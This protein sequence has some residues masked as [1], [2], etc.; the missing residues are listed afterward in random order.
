LN[1]IQK[2]SQLLDSIKKLLTKDENIDLDILIA[3]K[4][5]N[6]GLIQL[7]QQKWVISCKLYRDFLKKYLVL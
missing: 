7:Q 5:E 4:L 2:N 1:K 3:Y 6:M